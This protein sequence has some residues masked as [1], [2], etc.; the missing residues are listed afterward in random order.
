[1]FHVLIYTNKLSRKNDDFYKTLLVLNKRN[2]HINLKISSKGD[3]NYGE[4]LC[5]RR[6]W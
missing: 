2:K 4:I 6:K 5:C 1:M 3:Q